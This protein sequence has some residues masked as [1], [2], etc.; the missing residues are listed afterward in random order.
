MEPRPLGGRGVRGRGKRGGVA[1][2]SRARRRCG[3]RGRGQQS[4]ANGREEIRMGGVAN[5]WAVPRGGRGN[6]AGGANKG[7]GP[8]R[9][10]GQ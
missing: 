6:T 3:N 4:V 9:G 2:G 10:R 1:N 8:I 5:M 7:E